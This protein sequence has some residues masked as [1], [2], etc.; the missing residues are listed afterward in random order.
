MNKYFFG[1][2]FLCLAV[3]SLT[4]VESLE[5]NADLSQG[6][7]SCTVSSSL[8]LN[9]TYN[10]N[11]NSTV[12]VISI[13]SNNL[14][15]DCNNSYI[16][17][18]DTAF[19]L[20]SNYG[21][22][23]NFRNNVTI[24]NCK[25]GMFYR[26]Y[27]F[28][29]NTNITLINVSSQDS[30]IGFYARN[31]VGLNYNSG[32]FSNLNM[33]VY[34]GNITNSIFNN[35]T[36]SNIS[37]KFF[38]GDSS[39]KYLKNFTLSNSYFINSI[40]AFS[41]FYY[42][43]NSRIYSNYNNNTRAFMEVSGNR[44]IINT[45]IFGN[46]FHNNFL[47]SILLKSYN[48]V[49]IYSN[50]FLN[51]DRGITLQSNGLS[52]LIYQN[53]FT[54]INTHTDFYDSPITFENYRAYSSADFNFTNTNI[55]FN[56]FVNFGCVGVVG[57]DLHSF[58]IGDNYFYQNVSY[59]LTKSFSCSNEP[60]T[61]IRIGEIY[62]GFIPTGTLLTDNYAS[63]S[64]HTSTNGIIKNNVYED[65][66]VLLRLEGAINVT[67]DLINYKYFSFQL[68]YLSDRNELF[69]S[70]LFQ[71]VSNINP[72]NTINYIMKEGI[73]T[74]FSLNWSWFNDYQYVKNI[75]TFTFNWNRYGLT[76]ALLTNGTSLCN[77]SSSN[78]ALNTGNINITL[79]PG[80][81]CYVYDNFNLTELIN[82]ENSPIWISSSTSTE[83]Q[84]SSNLTD[85]INVSLTFDVESCNELKDI[86]Y[87]ANGESQITCNSADYSCNNN[88]VTFNSI[89]LN[90]N[91]NL[92][93]I[94][95]SGTTG[96]CQAGGLT[97]GDAIALIGVIL[98]VLFISVVLGFIIMSFNGTLDLENLKNI[99]L[100]DLVKG[101]MIIGLS[102]LLLATVAYVFVSAYCGAIT[103]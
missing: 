95:Y 32:N 33:S 101:V 19:L 102:G 70:S 5:C 68:P 40:N 91:I 28:R 47:H 2:M 36:F 97:F 59:L 56:R 67:H 1:L 73:N 84:I 23:M 76:S 87:T 83:K 26:S 24:Q 79:N 54:D 13:S 7:N 15:F 63:A 62:K 64:N 18:N 71:N 44:Q 92:F 22:Y 103:I 29:D 38:E 78:L 43:N 50:D 51:T 25:F 100:N 3:F 30:K 48:N 88:Q 11:M 8:T 53:N 55:S 35:L 81:G 66:N 61:A 69:I 58:Y 39:I 17:G 37:S 74:N 90:Q 21:L 27:F 49:S 93:S 16:Y 34:I 6:G 77:G 60:S 42:L 94:E 86:K 4:F 12:S 85:T 20:D 57:R 72:P 9:G 65:I 52:L 10:I 41:D 89:N 99:D 96:I 82:R 98:T 31:I 45:A 80:E 46:S 75:N 14:V